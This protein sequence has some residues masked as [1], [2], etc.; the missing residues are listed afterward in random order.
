MARQREP[1]WYAD[2]ASP[3][4]WRWWDGG[5]WT[6]HAVRAD[7]KGAVLPPPG[8]A[9]KGATR[10]GPAPGPRPT[11]EGGPGHEEDAATSPVLTSPGPAAAPAPASEATANSAELP[12]A[13]PPGGSSSGPGTSVFA[14]R[15]A[16]LVGVVVLLFVVLAIVLR[17]HSPAL[18]WQG[19]PMGNAS[20]VLAEAQAAM[21]ATASADE[22]VVSPQSTCYF[23]LPNRSAHDVEPFVRCGP[24]FL[25][26]SSAA[27]AW[28]SYRLGASP[29]SSGVKLTVA[30][31]SSPPATTVALGKGEVLRRPGGGTPPARDAGL[32]PPVVP[33]Q[34]P[35]WTGVLRSPPTGLEPAPVGDM[36][37]DWG[38]S[39]RLV[40]FGE[41]AWLSS[42]LDPLGLRDAVDPTNSPY[43]AGTSG[44]GRPVAK[45]LLPAKGQVLAVAELALSPGE[46]AGQVPAMANGTG[47][48]G[49]D[50]P[51][52]SVVAGG[53]T[54]G[55]DVQPGPGKSPAN[56]TLA[57]SVPAGSRPVLEIADKG[58]TQE[59]SLA[60]GQV[61]TGPSVLS[62][63]GTDEP[64]DVNARLP[65]AEVHV[66]DA[67]LV[68]FAGSD[69]GT[70][71]P[72]PEQ[73]YLQVLA[74]AS[75]LQSSFLPAS[76]F[77]LEL[78]AGQVVAAQALPDADR[79]AILMGFLVPA[80]FSSGTVVVSLGGKSLRVPVDFP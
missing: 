24:V 35:G 12:T 19:E 46:A 60:S 72:G 14:R 16:A 9:S 39:Y 43:A 17:G 28:L 37:G 53:T 67:S 65:G 3:G 1:G 34:P 38:R 73:A 30:S 44:D 32:A 41:T 69:G 54:Q 33:R 70:V 76:D 2:P 74:S 15:W 21:R 23:G 31:S 6:E 25:P 36:I 49:A 66:S 8:T 68:W 75:P 71:P 50:R 62:R 77:T 63:L 40:A 59:V 13:R 58:L 78:P 18:Y 52:L 57:A 45:L 79:T 27:D 51:I 48:S 42:R 29:T 80:S 22:G 55:F 20:H 7:P 5:S 56:L 10:V 26:W 47:A 61:V 64:L 4:Q 11:G